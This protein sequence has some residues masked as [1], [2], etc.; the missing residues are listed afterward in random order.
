M[1]PRDGNPLLFAG[2]QRG[3]GT[4][5]PPGGDYYI[6]QGESYKDKGTWTHCHPVPRQN[7]PSQGKAQNRAEVND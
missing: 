5:L 2:F 3:P 4:L 1:S 6:L 7:H